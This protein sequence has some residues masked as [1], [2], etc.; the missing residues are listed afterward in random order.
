MDPKIYSIIHE[1]VM[2][3]SNVQKEVMV[4]IEIVLY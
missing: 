1:L 4:S 3:K 2:I